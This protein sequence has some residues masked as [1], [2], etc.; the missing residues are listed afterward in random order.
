MPA[1]I[2]GGNPY[3]LVQDILNLARARVNDTAIS[4][5]GS[6][7]SNTQP[8]TLTLLNGAWRWMQAA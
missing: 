7:L 4:I 2:T 5:D 6:L 3:P 1:I 8:Y